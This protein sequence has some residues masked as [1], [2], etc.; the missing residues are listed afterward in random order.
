MPRAGMWRSVIWPVSN[1]LIAFNEALSSCRTNVQARERLSPVKFIT[2]SFRAANLAVK[3]GWYPG[4]RYS[5]LRDVRRF[6]RLGFLDIDWSGYDFGR[7]L[8]AAKVSRPMMTVA[9]DICN[10]DDLERTLDQA[11]ELSTY[12]DKVVVVP[13]DPR[14]APVLDEVIP[15]DFL[16]GFSV[17][18]RYGGT[19]LPPEMFNRPVHLLGGRPDVQRRLAQQM[20]V[21]SLDCNRFTL[22]ATYGDF[23]DGD[24]FRPHPVGGYETCLET[25]IINV[26]ALWFDYF[27]S[28]VV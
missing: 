14:L 8:K 13:K 9:R 16:L 28:K 3:H 24:A 4:A 27:C 26:N 20:F 25:S 15:P 23:F 5:N 10:V 22:D 12:A 7:H 1:T 18:T 17:P 19:T 11:H 6:D 2:H 21:V